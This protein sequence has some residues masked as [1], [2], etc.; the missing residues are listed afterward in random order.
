[1]SGYPYKP[2][3]HFPMDEEHAAYLRDYVTRPALKLIRP[4]AAPANPIAS[5][6]APK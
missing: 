5:L 3:E 2:N 6:M 4:L 1:M